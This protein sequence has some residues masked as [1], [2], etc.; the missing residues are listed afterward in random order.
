MSTR[1]IPTF[2]A[3]A[4]S[5]SLL[6]VTLHAE[7]KLAAVFTDHAVLQR[8]AV[9]PIWGTARRGEKVTVTFRTQTL[10]TKADRDGA[11]RINLAPMPANPYPADLVVEGSNTLT[12]HDVLVGDVWLCSGQSNMEWPVRLSDY[13][14]T[15]TATAH[16]PL[17]RHF[18]VATQMSHEQPAAAVQGSWS[19]CTPETAGHFTAVGFFFARDVHQ[20]LGVPQG[21]L[22]IS[23]GGTP[24]ESWLSPA[25]LASSPHA[26]S[27]AQAWAKTVAEYPTKK[28]EHDRRM[29]EWEQRAAA[30]KAA[31]QPEPPDRPWRPAGPGL[32][33]EPTV[34]WQGMVAPTIPYAIRGVLWYQGESNVGREAEYRDLFATLIRGWRE[35]WAAAAQPA[36]PA[37][38][39]KKR[40]RKKTDE[41][42][43]ATPLTLEPFPF[44]FVQLPNYAD[45]TPTGTAWARLREAQASALALPATGMAV[46]IDVGESANLHPPH[47]QEIGRRLALLART[48]VFG[49][50]LDASGPTYAEHTFVPDGSVR[51]RFDHAEIG[52][53]CRG[54]RVQGFQLAGADRVFQ[55][56]EARIEGDVVIVSSPTVK[57]P[58][59]VRYAFA[60][61]PQPDAN[62][63]NGAGLPAAPFR[64]DDW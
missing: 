2:L 53:V 60:N 62:L 12:L 40:R 51:I 14:A 37:G 5:S 52:L 24:L 38:E 33:E 31:G 21:L 29:A 35:A 45:N 26:A 56:A 3:L 6:A 7:V 27:V 48:Q 15:E 55:P 25:M 1:R 41:A 44:L 28:A 58:M 49:E 42:A 13:A 61:D 4:L 16:F 46:A 18:K 63:Y 34:V 23:W 59:A 22:N 10:V 11:W 8:D 30:A 54:P 47:K 43:V 57:A 32:P 19:V 9:V 50:G 36:T 64:T 20:A 17:I 39:P